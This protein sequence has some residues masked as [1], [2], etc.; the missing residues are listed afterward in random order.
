MSHTG[1]LFD[2]IKLSIDSLHDSLEK[3]GMTKDYIVLNLNEMRKL[4]E[5]LRALH[6]SQ[7]ISLPRR[8]DNFRLQDEVSNFLFSIRLVA[9]ESEL[10]HNVLV[11]QNTKPAEDLRDFWNGTIKQKERMLS[12]IENE[13]RENNDKEKK[14]K[15]KNHKKRKLEKLN[16][17]KYIQRAL[18]ENRVIYPWEAGEMIATLKYEGIPKSNVL[19]SLVGSGVYFKGASKR[20]KFY[21][22]MKNYEDCTLDFK[23]ELFASWEQEKWPNS[24]RRFYQGEIDALNDEIDRKSSASEVLD[25]DF[26]QEW[27]EKRR[28][29]KCRSWINYAR[30]QGKNPVTKDE[31]N[32][33]C[34]YLIQ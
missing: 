7:G 20:R 17:H 8:S 33:L 4:N 14:Q 19:K 12:A 1:V 13:I 34:N 9:F 31:A 6:E 16:D 5:Y 26:A 15:S 30:G 23:K 28:K 3:I 32:R 25:V 18:K 29:A 2:R 24:R 27:L 21:T 22:W 11:P 10:S